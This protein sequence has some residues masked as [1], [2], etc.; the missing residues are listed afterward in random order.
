MLLGKVWHD[1]SKVGEFML[2]YVSKEFD[3]IW[4]GFAFFVTYKA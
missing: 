4:F 2:V 3:L 1:L